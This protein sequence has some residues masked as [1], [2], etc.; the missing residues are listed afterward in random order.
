MAS[1]QNQDGSDR[2]LQEPENLIHQSAPSRP[3][4][5]S[6]F[7]GGVKDQSCNFL[8][9][10]VC[11]FAIRLIALAIVCVIVV[12]LA[13]F[14]VIPPKEETAYSHAIR[15]QRIGINRQVNKMREQGNEWHERQ[16]IMFDVMRKHNNFIHDGHLDTKEMASAVKEIDQIMQQ[17]RAQKGD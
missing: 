15:N 7:F 17:R 13:L 16:Q 1:P 12:I 3:T 5:T 10:C 9:S 8:R 2:P 14:G 6:E 11:A 4:R